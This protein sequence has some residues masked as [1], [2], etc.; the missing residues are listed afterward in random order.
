R[1]HY[2]DVATTRRQHAQDVVLYAVVPG[3]HFEPGLG[4]LAVPGNQ[5]PLGL[6]P[7]VG[8]VAGHFFGEV[9]A[10]QAREGVC[11]FQRPFGGG[12][13]SRHY[14]S[15]LGTFVTQ[16]AGEAAGIDV[17]NANN[18]V[19]SQVV[20]K[21]ALVAPAAGQQWQVAD[22]HPGGVNAVGFHVFVVHTGVADVRIRQGD[23]LA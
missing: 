7:L 23:D 14:G 3:D 21:A 11:Q 20:V 4:L 9:H 15:V 5:V 18:V 12:I 1:R 2:G 13:F 22:N 19:A 10:F 6:A 8:F 17:S 16:D